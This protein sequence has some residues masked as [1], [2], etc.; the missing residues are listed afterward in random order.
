MRILISNDDGV[1]APGLRALAEELA[2][3][4][5]VM[6]I[7]PD[8]DRSAASKSLTL[9]KPVRPRVLSNGFI[10]LDGTPADCVH[11]AL[12]TYLQELPDMVVTGINA[13]GNLGDDVMYSGT[14]A[15][16]TEGRHLGFPAIATS[17][18][19]AYGDGIPRDRYQDAAK[20]VARIVKN[21]IVNPLPTNTILNVNIPDLPLQN[22]TGFEVTRLG[23][24]HRAEPMIK[25]VDPRG[26]EVYWVGPPGIEQ[27]ASAGTDFYAISQKRVS[28]TPLEVDLTRYQ[29]LEALTQ[30]ATTIS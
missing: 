7:A 21:L 20:I 27:D 30:W 29:S 3:F 12:T 18:V 24:R 1:Y 5:T 13:G 28:I 8:R 2:E 14:V 22:I 26:C 23:Q 9:Y 15:A 11:F 17:L 19:G 4:A 25:S 16:A 6:V 10:S